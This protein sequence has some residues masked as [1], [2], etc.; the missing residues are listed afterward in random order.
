[1]KG[2]SS[3]A[4]KISLL[5][6]KVHRVTL[7]GLGGAGYTWDQSVE[8]EP[9]VV[10]VSE[11]AAKPPAMP[12]PGGPPPGTS[13]SAYN[14][15]ITAWKPGTARVRFVL[16]RPWERDKPPLREVVVDVSVLP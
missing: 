16:H 5:A 14:Y 11:E 12:A 3:E 13:S 15:V 4:S 6:G 7:G 1:M 2:P 9:G 8:G 10:S